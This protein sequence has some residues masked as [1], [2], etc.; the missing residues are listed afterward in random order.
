M[1]LEIIENQISYSITYAKLTA[2]FSFI[3]G[4]VIFSIYNF[5]PN[6]P[7]IV[8]IGLC[9]LFFAFIINS[10]VLM[11]L[12]YYWTKYWER[13]SKLRKLIL[14]I[15]INIPIAVLITYLSYKVFISNMD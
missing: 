9:F 12:I 3:I 15:C 13:R 10:L 4:I 7:Y 1:K 8:G 2:V 11:R 14:I 5:N 6:I